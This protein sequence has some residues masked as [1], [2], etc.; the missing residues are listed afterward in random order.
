MSN[1]L[2][3]IRYTLLLTSILVFQT[4]E[5]HAGLSEPDSTRQKIIFEPLPIVSYDTD[6][7]FGYGVKAFLLNLFDRR[8]SFDLIL[9]NSTKGERW[10]RF[11]FS[12]PD[13]ELRQG[14]V[15]PIAF[16]L[17]TD[18]D[19]YVARSFFGI[20]SGSR[21]DDREKYTRRDIELS[22]T[23]TRGIN[24]HLIAQ[25]GY[26]YKNIYSY[27]FDP[28]GAIKDL[29]ASQHLPDISDHSVF[30]KLRYD[31]RNSYIN[32]DSGSVLLGEIEI[33]SGTT[34]YLRWAFWYQHYFTIFF[35]HTVFAYRL[36]LEGLNGSNLPFQVLLPIGGNRSLRGY[37]QDRYLDKIRG[38]INLELRLPLLGNLGAIAGLDLGKVWPSAESINLK[39]WP[40]SPVVGLRYF[41]KTYIV[42]LD[43]GYST[44][45]LGI[46]FNFGHIF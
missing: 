46:Y 8:E 25:I 28:A 41:F 1:L 33:T 5:V 40:S 16:D 12:I 37:R 7:G 24:S 26:R 2:R 18:Y 3:E 4:L 10:Y 6:T 43:A 35:R 13:F 22:P 11:V 23:F 15:Y 36:G 17:V 29:P 30:L 34:K 20:G 38:L 39:N 44:E 31:T 27:N 19:K 14:T 9:F 32:P 21:Y 45:T 42:R